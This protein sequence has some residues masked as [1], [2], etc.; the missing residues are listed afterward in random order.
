MEEQPMEQT[1]SKLYDDFVDSVFRHCYFRISN[2]EKAK[3]LTQET[4]KRLW[5]YMRHDQ[6]AIQNHKAFIFKIANNLIIDSY[7]K[8]KDESL[9]MLQEQGFDPGSDDHQVIM[10]M[11]TNREIQGLL[12][13]L[14]PMYR[15]A[16][17]MRYV[18]DMPV[19]E[20]AI[21]LG[22]TEN[23]TSV[24]IYRGLQKV[25]DLIKNHE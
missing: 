5:E 3:D 22:E 8:K 24:R 11:A 16:V 18:D 6:D 20:I 9:D 1:F 15:D 12:E 14:D 10:N 4:F 25:R 13:M 17:V 19:K 2:W 7:R 21:L 23:N